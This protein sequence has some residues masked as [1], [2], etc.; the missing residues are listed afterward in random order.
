MAAAAAAGVL[1]DVV[2]CNVAVNVNAMRRQR[3]TDHVI[4]CDGVET[5]GHIRFAA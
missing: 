1:L 5:D 4:R 2:R 3:T